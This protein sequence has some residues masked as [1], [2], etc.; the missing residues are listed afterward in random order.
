MS[1]FLHH[2]AMSLVGRLFEDMHPTAGQLE[3]EGFGRYA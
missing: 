3:A 1:K 2:L